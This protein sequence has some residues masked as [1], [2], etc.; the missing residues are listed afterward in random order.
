MAAV[1]AGIAPHGGTL[2]NRVLG[3]EQRKAALERATGLTR[4]VLSPVAESDLQM[5]AIGAFS[6]LTG[7]LGQADYERVVREMRLANGL[8]WS[9]PIT[10]PV[11]PAVADM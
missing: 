8:V 7:F 10:L 1:I 6:P 4:V 5:I 2:I 11:E 3:G 9:I